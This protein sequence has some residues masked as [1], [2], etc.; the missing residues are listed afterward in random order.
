MYTGTAIVAVGIGSLG[1]LHRASLAENNTHAI[2]QW[3]PVNSSRLTG[4]QPFKAN[5]QGAAVETYDMYW[6][7]DSGARNIM[8]SS[9]DGYPH[10]KIN[11]DVSNWKW[12]GNGPYTI[13]YTAVSKKSGQDISTARLAIYTNTGGATSA[14]TSLASPSTDSKNSTV[15]T[16]PSTTAVPPK[17][18][19][20]V[21][22]SVAKLMDF[23]LYA[24]PYQPAM[25][26]ATELSRQNRQAD[27]AIM[28][29]I[30]ATPHAEWFG[31]WNANIQQD[32]NNYVNAA[33]SGSLPVLVAYNIPHRDCGSFSAGGA[34]ESQYMGWIKAM[35]TGIG[36]HPAVVILEPDALA[37]MSCLDETSAAKRMEL[38]RQAVATLKTNTKS[39]VY[40]DIGHPSWLSVDLAANL[41]NQA[42]V[43][44]ADGFSLNVSN[45]AT[46]QANVDYGTKLSSKTGGAH[47]V[48]DTGRNGNGPAS[49]G[50]WC[51][52]SGRAFGQNPTTQTGNGLVDAYLWVK[53][54]GESDG[55]C[56]GAPSAGVW[57]PEYALGLAKNAG[58]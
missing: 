1:L 53:T 34:E 52:P 33:P 8:P 55:N 28:Q 11:V 5:V 10:K 24:R 2:N 31:G 6:Q 47:F 43:T 57:M 51:N 13:T 17:N 48:V 58:W 12:R 36:S 39:F 20:S 56:N 26:S 23:S 30:A 16:T 38:L 41:L 49:G 50:E 21:P 42:G 25:Q 4:I 27:A 7:V 46:T 14:M 18:T 44:S 9:Y 45:F 35:A 37:Q 54:P 32:V 15:T 40:L 22:K 29:R 19:V 3:W